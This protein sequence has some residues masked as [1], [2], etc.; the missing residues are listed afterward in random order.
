M[1]TRNLTAVEGL[2]FLLFL[3]IFA[4]HCV[5][6]WLPIGWVGV[7]AF[8]VIGSFFLTRKYVA[9]DSPIIKVSQVFFRRIKRLYPIYL[10]IVLFF[11]LAYLMYSGELKTDVFWYIF[12]AQNFRCLFENASHSLDSFLGHFWYIGLDVWLFLI[13]V[14]ILRFVSKKHL[15]TAFTIALLIG[16]LWRTLFIIFVPENISIAYMI[17]IGMMDS[18]TLGGLVALNVK[19]QGEN[20][21]LMWTEIIVGL[22]GVVL[23]TVY[24]AYLH[25]CS[26]EESYQLYRTASGYMHNPIT[27]QTY[28]FVALFFAGMLRYC[29]DTKIKHPILSAA[30]LVAL[31]GMTYELYCF[32]LP[33]RY[34]A[35]HFIHNDVLMVIVAL[36]ATYVVTVLWNKLAMPIV[37]KII[38]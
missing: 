24:N 31:G 6:S 27:G 12:S 2:R 4:F 28:F 10:T 36:I 26:L 21:R 19:E 18:W 23:L 37:Q 8:L 14:L 9:Q 34:A 30:P 32:H 16:I 22:L 20:S 17:P 1:T 15:K 35:K 5:S 7:Q 29:T 3:G 11:T 38:R 25:G 33:V 13:W